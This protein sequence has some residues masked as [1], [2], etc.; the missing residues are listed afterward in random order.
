MN[1]PK[2]EESTAVADRCSF[3]YHL[4]SKLCSAAE[5]SPDKLRHCGRGGHLPE[6]NLCG[7]F[8]SFFLWQRESGLAFFVPRAE[9][10]PPDRPHPDEQL[11]TAVHRERQEA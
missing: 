6:R 7:G 10:D 1:H 8:R 4:S 3:T 11:L 9:R 2:G 5:R